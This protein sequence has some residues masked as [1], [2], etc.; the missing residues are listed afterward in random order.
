MEVIGQLH[1]PAALLPVKE[2]LVPIFISTLNLFWFILV[3]LL[4]HLFDSFELF[5]TFLW[6]MEHDKNI[7]W[8]LM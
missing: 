5:D 7:T 8:K 6:N 2:P 4:K 1:A 3:T